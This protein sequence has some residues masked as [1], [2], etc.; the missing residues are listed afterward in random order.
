MILTTLLY[1]VTILQGEISYWSLL[2]FKEL[3]EKLKQ[4]QTHNNSTLVLTSKGAFQKSE[5]ASQTNHFESEIQLKPA[6]KNL[7][8]KKPVRPKFAS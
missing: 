2:R 5:L 3:T 8:F 1:K 4:L 7:V 6:T